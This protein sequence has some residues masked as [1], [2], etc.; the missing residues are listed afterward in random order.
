MHKSSEMRR[1][2]VFMRFKNNAYF[3]YS[4]LHNYA[5]YALF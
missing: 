4:Y 5:K 1:K 3:A 2:E